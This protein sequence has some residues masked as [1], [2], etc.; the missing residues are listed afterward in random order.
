MSASPTADEASPA[1]A[2]ASSKPPSSTDDDSKD[3]ASAAPVSASASSPSSPSSSSSSADAVKNLE[4]TL[5]G[6]ELESLPQELISAHSASIVKLDLSDNRLLSLAALSTLPRLHTLILDKNRLTSL[7]SFPRFPALTTLWLNNNRL[8]DLSD[9]VS[10]LSRCCPQLSYLSMLRNP[11]VPDMYT[12]EEEM[13][14][15]QRFR[16]YVIHKLPSIALLDATTVSRDERK[17]AELKGE[18]CVVARPKDAGRA[19]EEEDERVQ[20]EG[21]QQAL[22][23]VAAGGS[24]PVKVASFIAKGKPRYDG[25]NSE[26]NRFIVND[27]L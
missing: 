16:W 6:R 9:T 13:E 20:A 7:A 27:D 17:E 24:T 23:G 2:D 3:E 8:H 25:A 5:S 15:Y 21:V 19:G 10:V 22:I 14:A 18:F 4:L 1:A 26:G 11:C 12:S